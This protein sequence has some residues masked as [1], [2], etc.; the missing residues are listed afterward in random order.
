RVPDQHVL[1]RAV[2]RN[3]GHAALLQLVAAATSE[4]AIRLVSRHHLCSSAWRSGGDRAADLHR[5]AQ[6]T[7][8]RHA[9]ARDPADRRLL[10]AQ[11]GS[12]QQ[13]RTPATG[14]LGLAVARAGDL[15]AGR[16]RLV[17]DESTVQLR[18]DAG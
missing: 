12:W 11:A 1:R 7:E 6:P 18:T 13:H 8:R 3:D 9:T 4:L 15:R 5:L 2:V 17:A 14:R 10:L 16:V